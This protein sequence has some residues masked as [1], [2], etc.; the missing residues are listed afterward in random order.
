MP[1]YEEY[2]AFDFCV[3]TRDSFCDLLFAFLHKG[4][5]WKGIYFK[6]KYLLQT[7]ATSFLLHLYRREAKQ[8]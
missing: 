4:P 1:I 7:A 6:R 5:F 8:M 2:G 3:F